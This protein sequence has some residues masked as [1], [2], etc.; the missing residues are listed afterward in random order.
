MYVKVRFI[1][2]LYNKF[3]VKKILE[4]WLRFLQKAAL[5]A[6]NFAPRPC[7]WQVTLHI[8]VTVH[9]YV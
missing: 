8:H 5:L 7:L 3:R 6:H 1:V 2:T 9:I 4:K